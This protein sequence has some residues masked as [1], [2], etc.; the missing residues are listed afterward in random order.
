MLSQQTLTITRQENSTRSLLL[1]SISNLLMGDIS[2]TAQRIGYVTISN[3]S[4]TLHRDALDEAAA[5]TVNLSNYG[6][7]FLYNNLVP[8]PNCKQ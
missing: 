7:G 4:V 1:Q 6:N 5:V 2:V 8:Y 3:G